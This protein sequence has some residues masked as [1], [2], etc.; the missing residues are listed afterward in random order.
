M[1]TN[2]AAGV[3]RWIAGALA[4]AALACSSKP[5][6]DA[7]SAA[8]AARA[9]CQFGAGDS[10]AA[11]LP[12]Y[13]VGAAIPIDH[14]VLVMQENRTFDHYFS[15]LTV[16]GQTV[17]GASPDATNPDPEHPG[18]PISR[19]HQPLLCFDGPAAGWTI[20]HLDLDD[21]GMDGFTTQNVEP[22]D[23]SGARALGY[24]D[25]TDLP[26]YYSL[27]NAFAISDRHFC[28]VLSTTYPNRLVYMAGTSFG[29]TS[30]LIP[31][32]MDD[33]GNGYPNVF[34]RLNDAQVG[35]TF[36]YQSDP[37][38]AGL[39]PS[40]WAA[41]PTHF[42]PLSQFYSDADAGLLPSVSWVEASDFLGGVSPAEEPPCDPQPGEAFVES[43]VR[44]VIASPE[45]PSL[46]LF[47][48]WDEGGGLYDHVDPPPA[49][50]PDGL[51]PMIPDGGFQAA[52]DQDG[53][54]VPFFVVS[55]YAKRGYVSHQVTDH[56]SILRFVEARFGLPAMTHRDANAVPPYDMFDFSSPP[57]LSAPTL[58]PSVV[59]AG[60]EASC[61]AQYPAP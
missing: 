18:A 33:A 37:P 8:A 44:S 55:P 10:A 4:S 53:M 57:D 2:R 52:F 13:P 48:T 7:G 31:P 17:D 49:C 24:Y 58:A 23:P 34:Q 1:T 11:T 3:W 38:S 46:A 59:D 14:V 20:N 45:W 50:V 51:A 22:R 35:W 25:G 42:A 36:Y 16:P 9:A 41:N 32:E 60:G 26:F 27:A 54:R 6:A 29:E 19:F 40:T 28:A 61:A 43:V 12:D 5:A 21:G 30:N 47:I 15:S 56:A 39:F